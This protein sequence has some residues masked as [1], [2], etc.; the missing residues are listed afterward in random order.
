MTGGRIPASDAAEAAD[1][2]RDAIHSR[3][4]ADLEPQHIAAIHFYVE[5]WSG[6]AGYSRLPRTVAA[7]RDALADSYAQ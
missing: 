1:R 3:E 7:L 6:D 2:R 4:L 5:R